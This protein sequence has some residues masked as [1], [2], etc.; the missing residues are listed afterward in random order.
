MI[1]V[2]IDFS[3]VQILAINI[4]LLISFWVMAFLEVRGAYQLKQIDSFFD[5]LYSIGY[6]LL[7]VL[8]IT[9]SLLSTYNGILY[10]IYVILH[11]L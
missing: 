1:S 4:I 7:I 11:G 10:I 6:N 9:I 3:K 5:I 8:A 2:M